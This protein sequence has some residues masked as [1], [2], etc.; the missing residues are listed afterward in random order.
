MVLAMWSAR[1]TEQRAETVAAN[2]MQRCSPYQS[3]L[4]GHPTPIS[5]EEWDQWHEGPRQFVFLSARVVEFLSLP[6]FL[7]RA[8]A[9]ASRVKED[10]K[11]QPQPAQQTNNQPTN[12]QTTNQQTNKPNNQ[13]TR[14]NNTEQ[15]AP[16][17]PEQART[18]PEQSPN[19]AR[20][21]PNK[22]EQART[23]PNKPEQDRTRPNK[24]NKPNK[25]N[26]ANKS[27]P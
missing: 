19:Q 25:P 16:N 3:V 21:S 4:K 27:T 2:R 24:T 1:S 7:L 26:K 17:K 11:K 9:P 6:P 14:T 13:H 20:T 22:P 5:D 23:S 18:S 10:D 8:H 12:K 15:Q